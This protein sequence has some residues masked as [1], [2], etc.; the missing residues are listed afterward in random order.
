MNSRQTKPDCAT[1]PPIAPD[2]AV[3]LVVKLRA[4][5]TK[6]YDGMNMD[7]ADDMCRRCDYAYDHCDLDG[8]NPV[9]WADASAFFLSGYIQALKD[10]K[11]ELHKEASDDA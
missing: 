7:V 11:A 2:R 8:Q 9:N 6:L 3:A 5:Y 1:T 4:V 10:L